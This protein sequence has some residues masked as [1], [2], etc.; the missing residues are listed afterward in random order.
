[1]KN[2]RKPSVAGMF[3]PA[4]PQAL[5]HS[6][7]LMINNVPATSILPNITPHGLIAPHAGYKYS[8][9]TAAY[10]YAQ[11]RGKSYKTVIVIA[12]SHRQY[13]KG[14]C[15]YDGEFYIT[16]LGKIPI[17]HELASKLTSD[18]EYLFEGKDGHWEEHA[19]EVHLPFLQEM[20]GEFKI[21][22]VVV[23]DQ[24]RKFV[25][26]LASQI[27]KNINEEILLVASSDL[28]HFYPRHIADVLDGKVADSI[29]NYTPQ[30]LQNDLE[31]RV[32]E[33]CGGGPIVAVMK[34]LEKLSGRKIKLLHRSDSGDV[35]GDMEEVV[36]YLSAV[37]Y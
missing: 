1:M 36:G 31:K 17:N 4:A 5:K 9:Q 3:Y 20:L 11:L 29:L 13:F 27:E 6:I 37:I 28:S 8:G 33:A 32:C 14:V 18:S 19:I 26:E 10:A 15:I 7:E 22:P 30:L 35:T 16:P 23:G 24:D 34:A 25:D 21:V 2:E 12:P